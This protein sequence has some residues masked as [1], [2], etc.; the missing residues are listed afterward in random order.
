MISVINRHRRL[1]G[2]KILFFLAL[3]FLVT[4]CE[5]FSPATKTRKPHKR[6]NKHPSQVD[7]EAH[8]QHKGSDTIRVGKIDNP[9]KISDGDLNLGNESESN[10][11]SS[12]A[13]EF[14]LPVVAD[15]AGDDERLS[16]RNDKYIQY[17]LGATLAAEKLRDEGKQF[18]LIV[19]DASPNLNHAS[20]TRKLREINKGKSPDII[21]GGSSRDQINALSQYTKVHRVMGIS[22]YVPHTDITQNNKHF[23]QLAPPLDAYLENIVEDIYD[24]HR[25]TDVF[26]TAEKKFRS[27]I[28]QIQEYRADFY[29]DDKTW[30]EIV[31]NDDEDI[32]K[33][34]NNKLD[35]SDRKAIFI[36]PMDYDKVFIY[37]ILTEIYSLNHLDEIIVYGLPPWDKFTILYQFYENIDVFMP[38][39]NYIDKESYEYEQFQDL[40]YNR[41]DA[42]PDVDAVKGYDEMMFIGR[43]LEKSGSNF[44]SALPEIQ[45]QGLSSHFTFK[46]IGDGK[47]GDNLR[48]NYDYIENRGLIMRKLS[49]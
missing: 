22:P 49:P 10:V 12:Y 5:L 7:K 21:V 4:S 46:R 6:V 9:D 2:N 11:K 36:I 44:T 29:D 42:L 35:I 13:V 37:K 1:N 3:V 47:R 8:N 19:R 26:I 43:M 48:D 17:Y 25:N 24:N 23:V 31:F 16:G 32:D 30:T 34:I 20:F 41:F 14:I 18:Q 39:M 38:T 27:R 15:V 28:E 33:L 45:Y 40:Y